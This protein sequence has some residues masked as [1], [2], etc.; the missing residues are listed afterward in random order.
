MVTFLR[1]I[2]FGGEDKKVRIL[3]YL[4]WTE[5]DSHWY[6]V[7]FSDLENYSF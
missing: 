2:Y 3:K 7:L 5:M 4:I 1:F 6:F